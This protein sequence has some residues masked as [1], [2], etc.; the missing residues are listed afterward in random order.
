MSDLA[1]FDNAA[2]TFPKPESVYSYADYVYRNFGVNTSRGRYGLAADAGSIKAESKSLLKRL[3]DCE[4]KQ[5]VY[6]ASA[7]DALNRIL[8]GLSLAKGSYVYV[9]PFEHNAVTR[10]LHHLEASNQIV[11]KILPFNHE[12][13][14]LDDLELEK[15]FCQYRPSL[16]VMTHA[17]NV[18]GAV[19]PV[20][21]V[22]DIAKQYDSIT[23][24]DMSQTAGLVP[25]RL[26]LDCIDFAVFAGHKTLYSPFGIGGFICNKDEKRLS[27]VLY[28]GNGVNSL[29]QDM[30]EDIILMEEI[31]SQNIYAIAGLHASVSWLLENHL[32]ILEKENRAKSNLLQILSSYSNIDIVGSHRECESIG[33]VSCVF[34]GY[35]PDEIGSILS[36]R[37]VA[38]R[39]G[40]HCAPFAHRFLGTLPAGTVRFSVSSF[41]SCDE[42]DLLTAALDLIEE[43]C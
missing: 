28:G 4:G 34:D 14:L 1:Y 30:P 39:T 27:P 33:V 43:S 22:F 10:V 21:H 37:G 24:T 2:T 36:A 18:C 40:L 13:L 16:V 26:G 42:F 5:V 41:T 23:V 31:S 20:E 3:L 8:L 19:L 12:T 15:M 9:S 35:S 38:V 29:E 25:L 7:T 32:E 6:T 11:L 17:S